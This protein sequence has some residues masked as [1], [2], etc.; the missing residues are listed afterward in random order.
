MSPEIVLL[1]LA[2]VLLI[3]ESASKDLTA[4]GACGLAMAAVAV[5]FL[6]TFVAPLQ[7]GLQWNDL[8]V[9]DGLS[10][11]FKRLFLGTTFVV[12]WS[13]YPSSASLP[14]ARNEFFIFPLFTTVGMLVLAS[15]AD[16]MLIFVALELVTISF[17]VLV[18]YQ[19]NT[20]ASLEAAVKYLLVGGL[21]TAFLVYGIAF[22]YGVFGTT[23]LNQIFL[24]LLA[25]GTQVITS[26][27]LYFAILLLVA[28]FGF[29]LA[30]VPFHAWAPDVY[31]GAPTPVTA[32]LATASKAAGLVV[33]M[34]IFCVEGFSGPSLA[35]YVGPLLAILAAAS[36]I[37][38]SLAAL[39]QRNTKRLLGYSS[40]GHA[41]YLLMGLSCMTGRG[42]GADVV[43]ILVYMIATLLAF[44]VI[45]HVE[46]Q[47]G[48]SDFSNYAGLSQREPV[49]ALGLV[50][51]FVSMAGI[52]PLAGF[53]GKLAVFTALWDAGS[54]WLLG[55]GIVCAIASLYYYLGIVR[56]MYWQEPDKDAA[57][58]RVVISAR[59]LV[60]ALSASLVVLGVWQT[61]L[62]TLLHSVMRDAVVPG[63]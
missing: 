2:L 57:P 44:F 39:P 52:P 21:S 56:A 7:D 31:Q 26:P 46:E 43:Y 5:T 9:S 15:A 41:G 16:F 35:F 50:V 62:A 20:T 10:T 63:L 27:A 58:V 8:Y 45:C 19:R 37:V 48:G 32:F 25:P 13:A 51:A 29:K 17:Y 28:G 24:S 6:L 40:I 33:L 47:L 3:L 49:M 36:V 34:R 54:F 60:L 12:L 61:P 53:V 30:A 23:S 38:G 59:V 14:V 42:Y 11:F 4:K 1:V 18:A 22:V 55:L